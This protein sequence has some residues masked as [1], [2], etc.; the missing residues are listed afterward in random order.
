MRLHPQKLSL[1]TSH[2][3]REYFEQNAKSLLDIPWEVGGDLTDNERSV[4]AAS[5]QG[6]Q[7]GESSEGRYLYRYAEKYVKQSNDYDYLA[8]IKLFIA[9]EQRHARDLARFLHQNDIP[10]IKTTLPDLVFRKLRHLF[11]GLEISISVLITAEIIAKVYYAALQQATN[12]V[13]LYT[14]CDQIL[15]DELKH[16]EFQAEQLWK[17]RRRR[18]W[19]FQWITMGMHCFLYGGTC[20]IVWQYHKK[21]LRKGDFNFRRFWRSCWVEFKDAFANCNRELHA[22]SA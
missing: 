17:L 18:Q 8:A 15:H 3:W 11:G 5:V 14:L 20:I 21:A 7:V 2:E 19:L 6:F 16:V 4:I 12:S 22:H 1:R 9:E 10:T 13:I